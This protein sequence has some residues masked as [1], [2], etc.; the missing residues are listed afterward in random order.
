MTINNEDI[1]LSKAVDGVATDEEWAQLESLAS[2]DPTI[3]ARLGEMTRMQS[4]LN[5]AMMEA[6]SIA[7]DVDIDMERARNHHGLHIHVRTWG[8][9]AVAAILALALFGGQ[10]MPLSGGQTAGLVTTNLS[11]DEAL[12]QYRTVGTLDGRFVSELPTI[13]VD[14]RIDPESGRPE[15]FYM[16]RFLER[17][18]V[19]GLYTADLDGNDVVPMLLPAGVRA[20]ATPREF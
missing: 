17:V 16:R 5:E 18:P 10:M 14:V 4:R 12:E 11:P 13:M 9:W 7:D 19:N 20:P 1:L 2:L 8:G 6:T 3:W 15:M